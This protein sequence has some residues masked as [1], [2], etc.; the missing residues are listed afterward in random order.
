ML[1]SEYTRRYSFDIDSYLIEKYSQMNMETRR[2]VCN[3]VLSDL[4]DDLIKKAIDKL[5]AQ[6]AI[7]KLAWMKPT[8]TKKK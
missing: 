1:N 4:D 3:L 8:K 7:A 5:V 2:T 6:H